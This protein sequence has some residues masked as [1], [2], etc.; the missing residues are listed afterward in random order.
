M[1]SDYISKA[2]KSAK[3]TVARAEKAL[4]ENDYTRSLA[5]PR[6]AAPAAP[7]SPKKP[8][9]PISEGESVAAGLKALQDNVHQYEAAPKYHDGGKIKKSGLQVI[10]AEKGESV[11]PKDA[12]KSKEIFMDHMKG[13]EAG[14][15]S[16]KKKA[17]ASP[18]KE[19]KHEEHKSH[20][21][22][23]RHG[24]VK[25]MHI[26]RA[27]DDSFVIDHQ[28]EPMEDGSPVADT[29]HT[30]P[31]MDALHDHL[32]EHM[33]EPNPGEAEADAG[34]AGVEGEQAPPQQ[35]A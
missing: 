1:G 2:L 29:Q 16:K 35:G 18:H 13:L 26:H 14:L 12:E 28:H 19:A 24:K 3:A 32:E 21:V 33:G 23:K 22:A 4:P 25:H 6:T 30:A 20:S 17:E 5:R 15:K 27:D 10:N 34:Q 7:A 8:A 9:A 11:L 31:D